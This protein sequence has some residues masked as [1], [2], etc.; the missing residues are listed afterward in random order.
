M[1]DKKKSVADILAAARNADAKGGAETP[2]ADAAP[3]A[4]AGAP[5]APEAK[6]SAPAAKKPAGGARMSVAEMMAAARAEKSG[7]AAP[8]APKASP[9]V[10]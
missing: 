1:A 10:T 2:L 3:E 9:L 8:A 7:G 5:S 4:A 6:A